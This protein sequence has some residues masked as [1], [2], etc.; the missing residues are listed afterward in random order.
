MNKQTQ[1]YELARC[2]GEL[3]CLGRWCSRAPPR[4][5]PSPAA[6]RGQSRVVGS[7]RLADRRG[8]ARAR[9]LRQLPGDLPASF[10]ELPAS[11][12]R[13]L[14]WIEMGSSAL[15]L[16]LGLGGGP[17][18]LLLTVLPG[19]L[20]VGGAG[21]VL[22]IPRAGWHRNGRIRTFTGVVDGIQDG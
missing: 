15:L 7:S 4:S 16:A 2:D 5:S 18:R 10:E 14:A 21:L 9:L 1:G 11:D 20:G 12:A 13:R 6:R 22:A 19:A 17:N 3:L 8:L